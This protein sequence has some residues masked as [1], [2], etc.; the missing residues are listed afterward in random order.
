M[1]VYLRTRMD[2]QGNEE[3]GMCP[4]LWG[5]AEH[6][7]FLPRFRWSAFRLQWLVLLGITICSIIVAPARAQQQ[8]PPEDPE[9]DKRLGLWLDQGIS[10][11]LTPSKSLE[12][13]FHERYDEVISSFYEYFF[14]VAS[15]FAC[16]RG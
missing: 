13:E 15:R 9:D 8:Q 4:F 1:R 16:G 14:K 6:G 7:W 3:I 11:G 12:T 5:S 2:Q 10:S